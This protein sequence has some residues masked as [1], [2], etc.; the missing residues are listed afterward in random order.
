[1]NRLSLTVCSIIDHDNDYI[2]IHGKRAAIV[3]SQGGCAESKIALDRSAFVRLIAQK[4]YSLRTTRTSQVSG[5]LDSH[6]GA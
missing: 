4:P 5:S 2:L 6:P 3:E 1:M